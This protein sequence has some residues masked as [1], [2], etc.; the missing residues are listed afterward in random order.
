MYSKFYSGVASKPYTVTYK[1]NY[2]KRTFQWQ[3]KK[4]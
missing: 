3:I 2:L 4:D 1:Y